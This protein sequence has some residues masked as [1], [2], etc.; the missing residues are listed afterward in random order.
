VHFSYN[1][2]MI[3]FSTYQLKPRFQEALLPLVHVFRRIG[4]TPNMITIG[5]GLFCLS[6]GVC[7]FS[8]EKRALIFYPL[9]LFIRMML[10]ALDGLMAKLYD[11][12]SDSGAVLNEVFDV[13]CDGFLYIPF[14]FHSDVSPIGLSALLLLSI[15]TEV[16][17]LSL[18]LVGKKRSFRGPFGKS[19]RALFF[20]V[21]SLLLE[22]NLLIFSSAWIYLLF[23]MTLSVFTVWNRLRDALDR[24]HS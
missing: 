23:G 4:L 24:T 20:G 2:P 16:S 9:I 21:L 17:G 11:L 13:L 12:R 3:T 22:F 5:T 1:F 10:N 7:V 6:F 15:L 18:L 8:W 14:L 19:D